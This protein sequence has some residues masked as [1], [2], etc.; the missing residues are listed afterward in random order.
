MTITEALGKIDE[1]LGFNNQYKMAKHL[2]V[3][4]G[5]ISNYYKLGAYPSL[6]VAGFIYGEYGFQIEP[7]TEKA[8][9][10]EWEYQKEVRH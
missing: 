1:Q 5:T 6:R 2:Q 7:F 9:K 3:S 10:K 4:Q 8:L